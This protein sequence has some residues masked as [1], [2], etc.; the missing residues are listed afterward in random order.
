MVV[1]TFGGE[2]NVEAADGAISAAADV[3][4]SVARD[5]T[6]LQL[7]GLIALGFIPALYM[8]RRARRHARRI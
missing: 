7:V 8:I 4:R 3:G 5:L 6:T 1:M 2:M